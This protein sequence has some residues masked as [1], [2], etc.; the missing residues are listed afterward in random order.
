MITRA[1]VERAIVD[2][3]ALLE[4]VA[5]L[6]RRRTEIGGWQEDA[7]TA[8]ALA[9]ADPS[10][11]HTESWKAVTLRRHLF[12]PKGLVPEELAAVPP[13]PDAVQRARAERVRADLPALAKY[14]AGAYLLLPPP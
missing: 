7:R 1:D 2:E 3:E 6:L 12:G 10:M 8:L 11:S 9:L 13:H 5:G 4:L 14:R